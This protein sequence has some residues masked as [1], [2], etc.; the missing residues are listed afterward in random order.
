MA[1]ASPLSVHIA[2]SPDGSRTHGAETTLE[3]ALQEGFRREGNPEGIASGGNWPG[4]VPHPRLNRAAPAR[5]SMA[6]MLI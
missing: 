2:N 5:I 4:R 3:A 1:D 6:E